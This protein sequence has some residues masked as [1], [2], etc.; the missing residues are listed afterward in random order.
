MIIK[1]LP[2][3]SVLPRYLL[4]HL[5]THAITHLHTLLIQVA[6]MA[7][8]NGDYNKAAEMYEKM[9]RESME[10]NLGKYSAKGHFFLAVLCYMALGDNVGYKQKM[11][12]YSLTHSLTYLLI[13]SFIH[14][15]IQV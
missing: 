1:D 10:S 15:L 11:E 14:S 8:A 6:A 2:H 9:G 12:E 3:R 4:T 7:T 5:I 13:H